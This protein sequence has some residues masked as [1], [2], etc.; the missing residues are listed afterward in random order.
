VAAQKIVVIAAMGAFV[1]LSA[2]AD[3]V[4]LTPH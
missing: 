3:R 4:A 2:E 1:Y